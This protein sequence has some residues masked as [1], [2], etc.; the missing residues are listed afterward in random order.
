MGNVLAIAE[1]QAGQLRKATFPTLRFARQA[2]DAIGAD[3]IAVV[4]GDDLE[5][6][7]EQIGEYDVDRVLYA[8]HQ[9]FGDYLAEYYAPAA[10]ELAREANAE[11]V[12]AP[13][14]AQGSDFLPRVAVELEAGM[15]TNAIDVWKDD[16][17]QFKRPIWSGSIHKT[18]QVNTDH[19]VVSVRTP[20]FA[21]AEKSDAPTEIEPVTV[22]VDSRDDVESVEL[23]LVQSERPEL[24][25]ADVVIAGGRGLESAE[26]FEMLEE[27]A[28]LFGGAVGASRAAV[29]S[30]YAPNDWQIGQTGKVVAPKLYVAIAIS[31]AIQHLSGMKGSQNIVAIN[32]D[33]DAPI[34]EISDYGLVED[35]FQAV[36]E[37][38]EK[39]QARGLE[40]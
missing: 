18:E 26:A 37:L 15:V 34:F 40:D 23:E 39:L 10:A 31:G 36:P 12:C 3:L 2:A 22:D 29:D 32:T 6:I 7:A 5:H 30:G 14:S 35:A 19:K 1:H 33:P 9:V 24:T 27:L 21:E 8:D 16:A 13:A 28:D 25:D 38:I 11:V 20:D 4:L 17:L